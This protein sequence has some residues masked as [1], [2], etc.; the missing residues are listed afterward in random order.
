MLNYKEFND[1]MLLGAL[2][3]EPAAAELFQDYSSL[4][5]IILK[6][7]SKELQKYKGIGKVKSKQ[8]PAV[9]E[10]IRRILKAEKKKTTKIGNPLDV[11]NY[12]KEMQFLEQ[13]EARI[14]LLNVKSEIMSERLVTKGTISN[15]LLS[16]REVFAP[17]VRSLAKALV[18]VHNHPSGDPTPSFDDEK[19]TEKLSKAAKILEVQLVDHVIIG[20]NDFTSLKEKMDW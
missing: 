14:L 15:S 10:I 7:Y 20:R 11:Y 12:F 3:S 17:A 13:E 9:A 19:V 6:T 16:P 5:E 4:E 18:V 2:V 8:I 1:Q